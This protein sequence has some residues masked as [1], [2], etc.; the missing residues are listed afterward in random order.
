[1]GKPLFASDPPRQMQVL[2]LGL[3]RTGTAS[4]AQALTI[5]GYENVYHGLKA[6]DSPEDWFV[7]DRAADASFPTLPTYTGQPFT[8]VEWDKVFGSCEAATDLASLFPRQLIAAYPDAKIVLVE[9]D[10]DKWFR[11]FEEGVLASTFGVIPTVVM[12]TIEPILGSRTGKIFR[13][14]M[15][16]FFQ[17]KDYAG[18]KARARE[19]YD[20]HYATVRELVPDP[21][22]RLDFRLGDGW[23]PLCEF[24]GKPIPDVPFP[25]INE[26]AELKRIV[27]EKILRIIIGGFMV[28]APWLVGVGVAAA[29]LVTWMLL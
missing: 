28:L 16:G 6:I 15:L 2:C 20:R 18:C 10:F 7:F 11:S 21:S 27:K 19:V 23:G 14:M 12:F 13:K 5:L 24:L 1:M 29:S 22:R 17:S 4:I 3:L 9:R 25:H 26:A 8:R